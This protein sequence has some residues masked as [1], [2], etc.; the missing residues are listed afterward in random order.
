[1]KPKYVDDSTFKLEV[2][3][4]RK[5]ND[6]NVNTIFPTSYL[7]DPFINDS[8]FNKF[9][10]LE[11]RKL[12]R[13]KYALGLNIALAMVFASFISL[14]F[15]YLK[16][17]KEY[18]ISKSIYDITSGFPSEHH[19]SLVSYLITRQKVSGLAILASI[20]DLSRRGYFKIEEIKIKKK[21]IF[22]N[23]TE[24]KIQISS[25]DTL[26]NEENDKWDK[27]V[28]EFVNNLTEKSPQYLDGVFGKMANKSVFMSELKTS[29]D[30]KLKNFKWIEYPPR[31]ATLSFAILNFI[32]FAISLILLT[33]NIPA[34]IIASL[35]IS[36]FGI[37]GAIAIN[38]M[39]PGCSA[40]R[41]K[42]KEFSVSLSENSAKYKY[43]DSNRLLQYSIVLGIK[44]ERM[45]DI[46]RN[47]NFNEGGEFHWFYAGDSGGSGLDSFSSMID[48][49]S[50]LSASF[51]SDGGAA[52]EEAE[53]RRRRSWLSYE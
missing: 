12:K 42:W 2:S 10:Y 48:T 17:G 46:I 31:S 51:G 5:N 45:K 18:R 16:Y 20:L 49:G 44:N 22:G 43:I 30:K 15:Q 6:L 9:E 33:Y 11:L 25:G 39:T 32:L 52:A 13:E 35:A 4:I 37:Y 34:S 3:R 36:F 19:P 26:Y 21:S 41:K 24:K 23:K 7:Q 27:T 1:M 28:F 40:L 50:T 14:V 8:K 53:R 38:R 29:V 47:F